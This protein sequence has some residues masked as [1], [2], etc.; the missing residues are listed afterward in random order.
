[1]VCKKCGHKLSS[2]DKVCDNCGTPIELEKEENVISKKGKHIDIEDITE[3]KDALS[4]NETKRGVRNFLLF[5]L[6]GVIL[7]VGYIVGSFIL[8]KAYASVFAKYEDVLKYSKL[9]II[10][11]GNNNEISEICNE[12]S[13]N[14]EFDFVYLEKNKISKSKREKLKKELNIYNVNS[15]VVI[16]QDG[17]PISSSIVKNKEELVTYLQKNRVIPEIISDTNDTLSNY[18]EAISSKEE[19]IIYLPTSLTDDT[20][21]KSE[22]ISKISKD[23]NL[24]YFEVDGYLLSYKQLKNIMSQLGFSEIQDDLLLYVR[25]GE[26]LYI[27]DADKTSEKYYFQLLANR[28]IIDVTSGEYLVT[29][30]SNKFKTMVEEKGKHVFF[31]TFDSCKYCD[32]VQSILSQISKTENI[33]IY[34]LDATKEKEEVSNIIINLGYKDGLTITPF[35]L[36]VE[37][38]KY[39]DSIIGMADKDLYTNKFTEYGVIK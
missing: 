14:Y 38:N 35:V 22:V 18:K 15:T 13:L 9:G 36:I 31:I 19:A 25:N 23:N 10:Y 1:M 32:N 12:Y 8:D 33:E 16:V 28:G 3:E 30:S 21:E 39:I 29:I 6:L 37:N 5:L 11:I 27:L 4:F 26:I 34:Y 7:L 20:K 2:V 24:N 17:V